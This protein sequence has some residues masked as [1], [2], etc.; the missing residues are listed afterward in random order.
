MNPINGNSMPQRLLAAA[1]PDGSMQARKS[2]QAII[3]EMQAIMKKLYDAYVGS[4]T[5]LDQL[6]TEVNALSFHR[7]IK[8][9]ESRQKAE[10]I[11]GALGI[12]GGVAGFGFGVGGGV[13]GHANRNNPNMNMNFA[14]GVETGSHLGSPTTAVM[15]SIAQASTAGIR[16]T[17]EDHQIHS[18]L[19]R[20]VSD[21]A[22]RDASKA[23]DAADQHH[24]QYL[25]EAGQLIQEVIATYKAAV[26]PR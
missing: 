22:L 23:R 13:V 24:Q 19:A 25:Q 9:K 16:S 21:S 17:A 5:Q 7:A 15:N 12:V 6:A 11:S 2:T 18:D 8:A 10:I 3:L 26:L 1:D 4:N 14:M 20:N